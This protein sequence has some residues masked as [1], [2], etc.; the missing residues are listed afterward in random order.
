MT[1]RIMRIFDCYSLP[2]RNGVVSFA[3]AVLTAI[4]LFAVQPVFGEQPVR[5]DSLTLS[6]AV[7]LA[8]ERN[9]DVARAEQ[10]FAA[11]RGQVVEARANA[12]PSLTL[13]GRYS[14]FWKVPS[15]VFSGEEIPMGSPNEYHADITL[16]QP[17]FV[18]GL[19]SAIGAARDYSRVAEQSLFLAR[20]QA[21]RTVVEA[22]YG[23]LLADRL[24]AVAEST[25][26]NAEVH[27]D[28]VAAMYREGV[29]SEY[30]YLRAKVAAEN[31]RP[32]A[33]RARSGADIAMSNLRN[34]LAL[35]PDEPLVL[36]DELSM[37]DGAMYL[38]GADTLH[39]EAMLSRKEVEIA[40]L[41]VALQRR[42][43]GY[44]KGQRYPSLVL[45]ASYELDASR[46]DDPP[47]FP[48]RDDWRESLQA[49]LVL[50]VPLFDGFSTSGRISM[51][52]AELRSAEISR[53]EL[54]D[55]LRLE[56]ESAR[57]NVE[58]AAKRV[59]ALGE[60]VA[61]A[62]RGLRIAEVRFESGVGTS[63]EVVDA[64]LALDQAG[65]NHATAIHDYLV[66]SV[67]L[68]AARGENLVERWNSE[69]GR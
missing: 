69:A 37:T 66:G 42:N 64:R 51:A 21:V 25:L 10:E 68:A 56:V 54:E 30:D 8:V 59:E 43:L 2:L 61:T 58:E 13:N 44:A 67:A 62:K 47:D 6:G 50:S 27:R 35:S 57:A 39:A 52:R 24:A 41:S 20:Q 29:L 22:Y 49:S 16:E 65:T 12:L 46:N 34:V 14:H 48:P 23:A 19:W 63:V 3:T 60:T 15:I 36:A 55:A 26:E 5:T 40:N 17:V 32:V 53:G 18:G 38:P 28:R 7:R 9:R 4:L 11:A 45:A 31:A 1:D 33:I